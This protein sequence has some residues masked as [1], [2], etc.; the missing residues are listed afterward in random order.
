VEEGFQYGLAVHW[1]DGDAVSGAH[2]VMTAERGDLVEVT[3]PVEVSPGTY[4][5]QL[6]LSEQGEWTVTVAI[7]HPESSGQIE[8]VQN[9]AASNESQ[10]SV[11]VDTA[12]PGRVGATPDPATSILS[13][14]APATTTSSLRVHP[15]S[16]DSEPDSDDSAPPATT[17]TVS[18]PEPAPIASDVVVDIEATNPP[19]PTRDIGLRVGHLAAIGLWII[20][21]GA[22]LFGRKNRTSV[23]LAL[24]GVA[25]TLTTGTILMIWGAPIN[26][27][28][29]FNWSALSDI[30][31]GVSYLTSFAI[32]ISAVLLAAAATLRWAMKTDR[33]AAWAT[34]VAT[35]VAVVS[36]TAMSQYHVLS[37]T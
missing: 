28:G 25:L 3:E 9:V 33:N 31:Y 10:W 29:I 13:P 22:A 19:N 11:L 20:P 36:V 16:P 15:T 21:V 18:D 2:V 23:V 7:H 26:S 5:G 1:S 14:P 17:P 6:P 12:D 32:K 35:A 4:G 27:P 30:P 24:V 34:L 37:H 8:F